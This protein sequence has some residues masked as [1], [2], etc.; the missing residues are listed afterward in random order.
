MSEK[1]RTRCQLLYI[2]VVL[3]IGAPLVLAATVLAA[4]PGQSGG[5]FIGQPAGIMPD[6]GPIIRAAASFKILVACPQPGPNPACNLTYHGGSLV[7]G[8]HT[9]HVVYWGPPGSSVTA[10]YHSLIERY[11]LDVAADSGRVTNVYATDT[12]Y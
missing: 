6:G 10:N 4:E 8:P 11:L 3:V 2:F 5:D 9:T 1:S 12:Q 7:I